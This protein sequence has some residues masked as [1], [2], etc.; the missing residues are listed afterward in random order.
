MKHFHFSS[1]AAVVALTVAP[2]VARGQAAPAPVPPT[3]AAKPMDCGKTTMKRHDHAAERG[4]GS[5]AGTM[6]VSKPCPPD[7]TAASANK[8]TTKKGQ[9]H[10]HTKTK[11]M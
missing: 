3:A 8:S 10:D 1:L 7:A 11:N 9:R 6:Q 2:V 5:T 4:G